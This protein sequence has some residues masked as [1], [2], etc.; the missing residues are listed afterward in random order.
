[1]QSQTSPHAA[2]RITK[3]QPSLFTRTRGAFWSY[4]LLLPAVL[5]VLTFV[6]LP[7]LA[8]YPYTLYNWSGIGQPEQ[9][10]GLNN[11]VKVGADPYFWAAFRRTFTYAAV[12]VP[13]QLTLALILALVLNNPKLRGSSIYRAIFFSP[14]VTSQA[15]VGIV[16]TFL[17]NSFNAPLT[18]LGRGLGWLGATDSISII[19]DPRFTFAAIIAVGI[20]HSLG[21]NLIYFLAALQSIPPELYEAARIDGANA[22]QEFWLI[23]VPSLRSP[24]LII[25]FLAVLGS[26]GVFELVVVMAGTGASGML[27]NSEVVSTYIYRNAFTFS[28]GGNVGFAS[29]A[30]LLMGVITLLLSLVQLVVLRRFGVRRKGF[31]DSA[32]EPAD[33]NPVKEARS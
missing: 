21:V 3:R 28:G 23:T 1:M 14:V 25:V 19:G 11:F 32:R 22:R 4:L 12:L 2:H 15:V 13:I 30:A 16:I 9:Y 20:W 18:E 7:L 5:L 24:G 33:Q 31:E 10:V 26:L 29:A 8:S 17:L 6:I 27:S